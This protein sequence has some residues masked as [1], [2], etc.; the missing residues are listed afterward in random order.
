M[1]LLDEV[2]EKFTKEVQVQID[3]KKI[4]EDGADEFIKIVKNNSGKTKIKIYFA[5]DTQYASFKSGKYKVHIKD[6]VAE[7]DKLDFVKYKL[8]SNSLK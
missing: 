4:D 6:F 2:V 5:N 8:L 7:L 3:I 1:I